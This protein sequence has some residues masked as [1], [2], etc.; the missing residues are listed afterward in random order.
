[1]E[2]PQNDSNTTTTTTEE[3]T[4]TTTYGP[5]GQFFRSKTTKTILGA[6][7]VVGAGAYGYMRF[8][9][10]G[11]PVDGAEGAAEATAAMVSFFTK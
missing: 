2:F 6:A 8:I 3:T 11:N 1:M 4:T 9:A 5:I 10:T 7:A